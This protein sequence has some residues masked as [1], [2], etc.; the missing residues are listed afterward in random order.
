MKTLRLRTTGYGRRATG[1]GLRAALLLMLVAPSALTA[2]HAPIAPVA[3]NA[4]IAPVPLSALRT[5]YLE[6]PLGID[7]RQPRLSWKI[8]EDRRGVVQSAYQIRVALSERDLQGNRPVLWDSGRVTSDESTQRIYS[9]PALTSGRR[10]FWQVRVWNDKG[11]ASAWSATAW[12][13]MGLLTLVGLDG[14]VDRARPIRRQQGAR[15][16]AVSAPRIRAGRRR[17]ACASLRHQ[18][19]SLRASSER[20]ARRRSAVHAG[21]DELQQ[22]APVPDVRHHAALEEGAERR[23]RR[24][25][26]RLV[27]RRDRVPRDRETTTATPS[28]CSPR[29]TS[30][31]RAA[32]AWSSS[33]TAME[34]L[35]RSDPVVR[36]LLG[37]DLRRAPRAGGVERDRLRRL[38]LDAGRGGAGPHRRPRGTGRP[39]R[40]P[41]PGDQA[42]QDSENA[43]RRHRRRHGPEHGRL[44]APES[45]GPGRHD[46]HAAAR[47]SP[48]QAGQLLHREPAR[49][50]GGAALHAQRRRAGGVRA[51]LHVHGIPLRCRGRLSGRPHPRQ[52]DRHRRA[53][54]HGGDGHVRDVEAAGEPAAAQHSVGAEGQLPRRADRLPAAGR[55]ARLDRRRAGL[56]AHRG[57]QHGRGRLLHEVAEGRRARSVP[58]RRRAARDPRRP[59]QARQARW[60]RGRM[61]GR[62]RDHPVEHV[63]PVRRRAAARRAVSEHEGLGRVRAHARRRRL[64]LG[65]RPA[66]RRLA[67]VRHHALRLP[68]RDDQQGSDRDGVLRAFGGSAGTGGAR[69]RQGRR[70][71]AVRR[72]RREGEGRVQPR[73]RDVDGP[74][75][76]SDA[77]GLRAGPGVQPAA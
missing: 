2:P 55:A 9:G 46:G 20:P 40:A 32:S 62:G 38:A 59:R 76:R 47:R 54:G 31:S 17:R 3:P 15:G 27:P 28:G 12:W 42:D 26:Q 13:E 50:E 48:R 18:P 60:R 4:P 51:A 19:R 67:G 11:A 10:Y 25:G 8:A 49:R 53:L 45:P 72:A 33:A 37:R 58:E 57:L 35:H 63:P 34:G 36:D 30:R 21:L 29:S 6:N 71:G 52:P 5:E 65:R 23:R 75:W 41:H 73:V 22:A 7:V 16:L 14:E 56:L 77:D 66:L 74:R 1:Y 24:A 44:G 61:G 43:R 68:G 69:A 39:A 64:H 70:G